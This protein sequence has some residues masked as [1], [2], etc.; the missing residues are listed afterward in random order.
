[1]H[2]LLPAFGKK[3]L[4]DTPKNY[5]FQNIYRVLGSTIALYVLRRIYIYIFFSSLRSFVALRRLFA[6]LQPACS[7]AAPS[8]LRPP[9]LSPTL[10]LLH[11]SCH[12][13]AEIG[14]VKIGRT[15]NGSKTKQKRADENGTYGAPSCHHISRLP[16]IVNY[17]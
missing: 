13:L 6:A 8:T 12:R 2:D 4:P 7:A 9:P 5:E 10:R 16:P 17:Q 15:S 11:S 14:R 3:N 1:M